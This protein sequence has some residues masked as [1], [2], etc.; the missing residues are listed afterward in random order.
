MERCLVVDAPC[1]TSLE[2]CERAREVRATEVRCS[3]ADSCHE[4]V[5]M[6][7][8]CGWAVDGGGCFNAE[9]FWGPPEDIARSLDN[10]DHRALDGAWERTGAEF[11]MLSKWE[12]VLAM[13][14]NREMI[15]THRLHDLG[16]P[17]SAEKQVT[18]LAIEFENID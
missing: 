11:N 9:G 6:D 10:C 15:S 13:D 3:D 7:S 1:Y 2:G 16:N 8:K 5:T 14:N 17:E 18:L 12:E 4:C